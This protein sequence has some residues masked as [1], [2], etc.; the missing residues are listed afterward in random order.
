MFDKLKNLY[1]LQKQASAVKQELAGSKVTAQSRDGSV[2]IV[3]NGQQKV[4]R[5]TV[6]ENLLDPEKK[7]S[8][9]DNLKE[10][11][12]QAVSQTQKAAFDTVGKALKESGFSMGGM[13]GMVK[14]FLFK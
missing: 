6:A 8:L 12:D 13:E 9:E 3:M 11:I 5:V 2:K 14:N 10:A 7:N 4:E 1:E